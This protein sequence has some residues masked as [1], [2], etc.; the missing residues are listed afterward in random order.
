MKHQIQARNSAKPR[1]CM[2]CK[3]CMLK[4]CKD[5]VIEMDIKKFPYNRASKHLKIRQ[6]VLHRAGLKVDCV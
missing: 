6:K 3:R 4:T 2:H 5:C 1:T